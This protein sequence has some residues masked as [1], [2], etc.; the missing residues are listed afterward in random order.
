MRRAASLASLCSTSLI[1]PPLF[2][3]CALLA[4]DFV[5]DRGRFAPVV[6]GEAVGRVAVLE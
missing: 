1:D 3:Q 2:K 4:A 5:P 6:R